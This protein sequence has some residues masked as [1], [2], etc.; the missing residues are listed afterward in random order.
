MA[1]RKSK[2][3]KAHDARITAAYNRTCSGITIPLLKITDVYAVGQKAIAD[4]ADDTVLG[5][6]IRAYVETIRA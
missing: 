5:E 3:E 6:K 1:K 4:G 2:K